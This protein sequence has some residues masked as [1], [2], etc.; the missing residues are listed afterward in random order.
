MILNRREW[1]AAGAAAAAIPAM[2]GALS[3]LQPLPAYQ[4]LHVNL[5]AP[6]G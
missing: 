1:I 2:G 3:F 4:A 5:P 6:N